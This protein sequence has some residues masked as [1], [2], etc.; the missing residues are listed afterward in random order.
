MKNI[1]SIAVWLLILMLVC[2]AAL[3]EETADESERSFP[4]VYEETPED[5][6]LSA[7]EMYSWFTIS[8][9]DV[10][11]E[12]A[13]GDGSV[14]RVA[15]ETLCRDEI[16]MRLLDFTFCPEIVEELM[17]YET[18]TVIDG[19]LYGTAG[20]RPVD[21]LISEVIY[22]ETENSE[23]RVVYTVTVKYLGEGGNAMAPDVLEFVREPVN[24]LWVFT[25]FPFFW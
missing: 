14:F 16:M 22:E 17:A 23:D 8:P 12:L 21:P 19:L 15:D 3:A 24:G 10:D 20:G 5:I 7:M 13:G 4:D 1:R 2:A 11:P 9:L 6:I 25:Q 18:Y